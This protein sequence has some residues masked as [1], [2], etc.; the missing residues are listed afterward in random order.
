M[1]AMV[2]MLGT[3]NT[4]T[5]N[6]E[7]NLPDCQ[8]KILT[9]ET[10]PPYLKDD[11]WRIIAEVNK[12]R[13]DPQRYAKE[14]LTPL[15]DYYSGQLLR[16]PG[17]SPI[18]T[19]E[20]VSALIECIDVLSNTNPM[21]LLYPRKGLVLAARDH[22]AD[23]GRSGAVGHSG[24]NA[25]S[26]V[27]RINR[28]GYWQG[29]AGENIAYG[30][31]NARKIVVALL[32]D[33]GVPS[34]GHRNNLLNGAFNTI[35]AASGPH[36]KFGYMCVME[37]AGAYTDQVQQMSGSEQIPDRSSTSYQHLSTSL[38]TRESKTNLL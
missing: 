21:P 6:Q 27:D 16:Y 36:N 4:C 1:L 31:E 2:S 12:M 22:V 18:I 8:F 13:C 17:R 23:Q 33:D 20:G 38:P 30:Y 14:Q 9:P 3:T 35:G 24:S 15:L 28:Y 5:A 10:V 34:R 7:T 11:E 25:S 32:I 29:Y 26:P 37:F 19:Q